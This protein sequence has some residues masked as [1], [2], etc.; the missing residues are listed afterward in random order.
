M[1]QACAVLAER[2]AACFAAHRRDS[3][4]SVNIQSAGQGG[5][6]LGY[7]INKA[8]NKS[9]WA[10]R[11]RQ[12]GLRLLAKCVKAYKSKK[13]SGTASA[14]LSSRLCLL[15]ALSRTAAS[16][17]MRQSIKSEKTSRAVPVVRAKPDCGFLPNASKH[18]K[19]RKQAGLRLLL[20]QAELCL[21]IHQAEPYLLSPLGRTGHNYYTTFSSCGRRAPFLRKGRRRV[22][23]HIGAILYRAS[24][25]SQR[26]KAVVF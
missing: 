10:C 24:I 9:N 2:A 19:A 5:C 12:A 14:S 8:Q 15:S 22:L 4:Q 21:H 20:Y 13:T 17:R 6:V 23:R 26:V 25:S 18:T 1:R 16:C 3:V 7:K 11:F